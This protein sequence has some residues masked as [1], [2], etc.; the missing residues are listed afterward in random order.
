MYRDIRFVLGGLLGVLGLVVVLQNQASVRVDFLF[1][2]VE[3]PLFFLLS[4]VLAL[5]LGA[6]YLLG[7]TT[8]RSQ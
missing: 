8:R 4:V 7:R 6:G 5:G 3:A 1:W 2:S